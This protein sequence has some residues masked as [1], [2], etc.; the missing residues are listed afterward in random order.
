[1]GNASLCNVEAVLGCMLSHLH[2]DARDARIFKDHT[3]SR[4][5]LVR[6]YTVQLSLS[7]SLLFFYWLCPFP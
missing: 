4:R 3:E 6:K 2:R 5:V 7:L 1:M